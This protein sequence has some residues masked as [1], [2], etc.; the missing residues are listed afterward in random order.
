M[1]TE[2]KVK[3]ARKNWIKGSKKMGFKI[4]TPY[5]FIINGEKRKAFAFLPEYGSPNGMLI[6]FT[7]SPNFEID[8]DILEWAKE[9]RCFYSFINIDG[10]LRYDE[11]F[12]QDSLGDWGK[13]K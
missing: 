4:I 8:K 7:S 12:I 2:E 6:G 10:S 5:H 1:L 11:C 13:F 9:Q 3:I